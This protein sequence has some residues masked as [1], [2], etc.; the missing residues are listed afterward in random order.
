MAYPEWLIYRTALEK[1][2]IWNWGKKRCNH[3][4][5]DKK[6]T[7]KFSRLLSAQCVTSKLAISA[8]PRRTFV[9]WVGYI[10][11]GEK[12]C[13]ST[14]DF[15]STWRVLHSEVQSSTVPDYS[16]EELLRAGIWCLLGTFRPRTNSHKWAPAHYWETN[17]IGRGWFVSWGESNLPL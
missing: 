6:M 3:H 5:D 15:P 17:S 10:L 8:F 14:D 7:V 11:R 9:T 13:L 2:N 1:K 12:L 4:P 16:P